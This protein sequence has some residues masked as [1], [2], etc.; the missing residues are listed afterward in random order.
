MHVPQCLAYVQDYF[1]PAAAKEPNNPF[2]ISSKLTSRIACNSVYNELACTRALI[3]KKKFVQFNYG[4]P[5]RHSETAIIVPC[6]LF[7]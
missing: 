6:I 3:K 4:N 7:L 5:P 2:S 1:F